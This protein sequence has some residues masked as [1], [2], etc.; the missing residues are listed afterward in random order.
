MA[1]DTFGSRETLRVG[2]ASYEISRLDALAREGVGHVERLPFSLK[3]LLENLLR[4]EDGESVTADDI[5]AL[6]DWTPG[7][8][9]EVAFMPAR[10][11]HQD[12]TGVPTMVDMA[13]MRDAM[14]ALGG[15]PKLINPIQPGDLVID[16]SVQV[17]YFGTPEAF[18]L[19][20]QRE[21]ERNKE[22]YA[23]LR[24]AQQAFDDFRVVPP[25]MGIVH[26]INLEYL[27]SVVF[28]KVGSDG[29]E[30]YP[31]TLVGTAS[32]TT[33]LHGLGVPGRGVG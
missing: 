12:L 20:A 7:A 14:R 6:A 1:R 23:L 24:W 21:M 19:N 32:H 16:H 18:A 13:A 26:Q 27:A 25:D 3:L 31:D 29:A 2:D 5:R 15:D 9:G 17:D 33:M 4:R 28:A 30:A 11:L 8:G 10:V 22:R